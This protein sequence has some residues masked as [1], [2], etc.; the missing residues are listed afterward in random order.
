MTEILNQLKQLLKMSL[1]ELE[2]AQKNSL[3]LSSNMTLLAEKVKATWQNNNCFLTEYD[4]FITNITAIMDI[5]RK[6]NIQMHMHNNKLTEMQS[7][8]AKMEQQTKSNVNTGHLYPAEEYDLNSE[9]DEI[10][11]YPKL[12]LSD[13][14]QE[15]SIIK[16]KVTHIKS[17]EELSFY[18]MDMSSE[19]LGSIVDLS[20]SLRLRQY[21]DLPPAN[22]IFGYVL[23]NNIFRAV[24]GPKSLYDVEMCEEIWPCYILDTGEILALKTHDDDNVMYRITE[25]QKS[26]PA[27]AILC[28][29]NAHNKNPFFAHKELEHKL[30]NLEYEFCELKIL[31][32]VN[33]YLQVEFVNNSNNTGNE[34][35]L[36]LNNIENLSLS[37]EPYK[38]DR[39]QLTED[40][41]EML[42]EEPLNTT[43]AMK[44]VM[45]YDPQDDKR[46]C[47][48][49]DPK[50]G[51]C[52]KGAN[53]KLEHIL[54]QPEGWTKDVLPSSSIM[55][56]RHPAIIYPSGSIVSITPTYVGRLDRFYA[57]I[58]DPHQA[59]VPMVWNDEDIPSWKR[60]K[61]PPYMYELVLAR[62]IDDLW[63]RAQIMSHDDDYRMFKVLYVDYGNCQVVHLRNLA[64]IDVNKAQ[65]PFQAVLCRMEAVKEN[66][67]LTKE[68]Q[69]SAVE[70]LCEMI[71]NKTMDVKVIS[72]Y[73]DLF[74]DFVDQQ[75]YPLPKKFIEMGF[76]EE[77]GQ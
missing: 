67:L 8:F 73:E 38:I 61:K 58:N 44:A 10:F 36:Q 70:I 71:L 11:V 17:L 55:D 54:P 53:C 5:T 12:Q 63:Y 23:D 13:I 62:Y 59:I 34:N 75:E 45:G 33:D 7:L 37:T 39:K 46:I 16:G 19:H 28:Q 4:S 64:S 69:K 18:I 30:K 24:L 42:Y 31:R 48:F 77:S 1:D 6:F 52:F 35:D 32:I 14:Y 60:L 51:A 25:E 3:H 43:N 29:L 56:C 76:L 57:Q 2:Q 22:E 50:T 21:H 20:K 9:C 15:N 66:I 74:I 65:V 41:L 49:Y 40:E 47:R 68:E 27:Q 26:I 72:H